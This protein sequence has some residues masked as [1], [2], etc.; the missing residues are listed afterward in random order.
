MKFYCPYA[1]TVELRLS[2]G[3]TQNPIVVV[4]FH[5]GPLQFTATPDHLNSELNIFPSNC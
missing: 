1:K 2:T 3:F 4:F 5:R